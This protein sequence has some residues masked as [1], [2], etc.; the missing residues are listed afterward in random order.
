VMPP[1]KF[2][3]RIARLPEVVNLLSA[4]PNGLSLRE[5]AERYDVDADS[6]REDLLTF[7]DLESWGWSH[8]IFR[9]PAFEFV[10]PEEVHLTDGSGQ[11]IVRLANR[12]DVGLGVEHLSAGDLALVYAAGL[13]RLDGD[14]DD[15][16]LTSA[17]AAIAETMYGEPAEPSPG[18]WHTLLPPLQQAQAERRRVRIE[19]SRAW[20]PGVSSR[21]IEPL[22]LLQTRRG[23]EVDAGPPDQEGSLRTFLL[24]NIR[25]AEVLDE[26][27]EPPSN[28]AARLAKQRTTSSVR[29]E[30]AQDARWAADLYAERVT[31]VKE[32]EATFTADLELLPPVGERVGLVMLASGPSTRVLAPGQV[33]PQALAVIQELLDHHTLAS[34]PGA[35]VGDVDEPSD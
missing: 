32:D 3:Q 8:D 26:T 2:I 11:T 10:Q 24:S 7:A 23:W 19:Y 35:S 22:R 5:L 1:P 31:V 13:S 30:L 33:L 18:D 25:T 17:L 9:R 4:F 27:F 6:M 20:R 21:T 16:N 29:L 14:P 15:A 28:L 34:A 12:E